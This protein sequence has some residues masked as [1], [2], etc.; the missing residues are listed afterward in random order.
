MQL[1]T[2]LTFSQL[3]T[4]WSSILNPIIANPITNMTILNNVSLIIGDNQIPHLLQRLQQGWV[5]LDINAASSIYRS[6][7]FN[8]NYLILNS[9]AVTTINLGVF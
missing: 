6:Q 4:R 8:S 1:P 7:P 9:S 2:R 3:L 5:I